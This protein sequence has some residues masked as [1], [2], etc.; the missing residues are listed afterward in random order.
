MSQCR[1]VNGE[2]VLP[3]ALHMQALQIAKINSQQ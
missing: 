2:I 1:S 3:G